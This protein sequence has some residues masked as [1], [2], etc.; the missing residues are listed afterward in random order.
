M[1]HNVNLNTQHVH[2]VSH[3]HE[4]SFVTPN[5][6]ANDDDGFNTEERS[7]GNQLGLGFSFDWSFV[8]WIIIIVLILIVI[9]IIVGVVMCYY[10]DR[11]CFNMHPMTGHGALGGYDIHGLPYTSFMS[12]GPGWGYGHYGLG[13]GHGLHC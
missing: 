10:W 3:Y 6:N 7:S 1:I 4:A 2:L 11:N 12:F 8:G 9:G 5:H 13:F